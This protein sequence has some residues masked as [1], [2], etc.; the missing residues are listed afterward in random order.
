MWWKLRE[1]VQQEVITT[2]QQTEQMESH[3]NY[4]ERYNMI[5]FKVSTPRNRNNFD[6][7]LKGG[8]DGYSV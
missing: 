6:M 4:I 3:T 2:I 1:T 8:H 5:I 7:V